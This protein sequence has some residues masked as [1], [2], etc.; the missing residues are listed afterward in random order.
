M[1]LSVNVLALSFVTLFFSSFSWAAHKANLQEGHGAAGYDVVSYIKEL[2]AIPGDNKWATS[3]QG[4]TYLFKS[5]ANREEFMKSPHTYVPAYG[6]WCAYAMAENEEVEVDPKT[7]KVINGKT[8]L[9]YNG[10]WGNTLEKWNKD[11][12]KLKARADAA[13]VKP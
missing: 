9:F 7:F 10:L 8:Y 4:V 3:Y 13:W 1:R 5:D 2:K 12:A 6:G 11:E